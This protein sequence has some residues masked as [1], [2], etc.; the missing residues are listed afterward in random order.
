MP[1]TPRDSISR[2]PSYTMAP[3][4][5]PGVDRV[6]QLGQNEL[7]IAPSPAAVEAVKRLTGELPRYPDMG[8]GAL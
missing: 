7:G 5:V 6:I 4:T 2:L 8:H 3:M 1:T